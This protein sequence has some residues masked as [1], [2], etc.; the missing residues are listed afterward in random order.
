M[1]GRKL[2][3]KQYKM[4]K[5]GMSPFETLQICKY[6]R[7]LNYGPIRFFAIVITTNTSLVKC[8][9]TRFS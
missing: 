6:Y 2:Q 8:S 3:Y 1:A 4:L 5:Q 9:F 7:I